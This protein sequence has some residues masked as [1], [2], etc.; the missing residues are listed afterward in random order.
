MSRGESVT[1][2]VVRCPYQHEVAHAV[3]SAD[4]V[5]PVGLDRPVAVRPDDRIPE[6][7]QEKETSVTSSRKALAVASRDERGRAA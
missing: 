4:G 1:A 5:A 2:N 6:T 3:S 7:I